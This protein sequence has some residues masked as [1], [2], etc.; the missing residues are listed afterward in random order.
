[1]IL[2]IL[3]IGASVDL[4]LP[5]ISSN[6]L[7][8][9][10]I[11]ILVIFGLWSC[12]WPREGCILGCVVSVSCCVV[13]GLM[14]GLGALRG[15][16]LALPVR[17]SGRV[18]GLPSVVVA[19]CSAVVVCCSSGRRFSGGCAFRGLFSEVI[20]WWGRFVAVVRG[21]GVGVGWHQ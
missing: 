20:I 2:L 5:Q 15:I 7:F 17:G 16:I 18:G 1:M 6:K 8:Y 10:Y 21:V 12:S 14:F 13:F 9:P 19:G 3:G 11:I 4:Y